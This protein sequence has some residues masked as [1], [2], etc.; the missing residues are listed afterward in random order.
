M[1]VL[2]MSDVW[3]PEHERMGY[4]LPREEQIKELLNWSKGKHDFVVHCTAGVSRSSAIAYVLACCFMPPSEAISVLDPYK[5][6][7]NDLIVQLGAKLLGNPEVL[8]E[9]K[10]F[11]KIAKIAS[12]G[13]ILISPPKSH[14]LESPPA[15]MPFGS[16]AIFPSR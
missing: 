16:G 14:D 4:Q 15:L 10:R 6:D 3:L 5:H 8:A 7:P 11:G 12:T 13:G 1:I 9:L 2:K